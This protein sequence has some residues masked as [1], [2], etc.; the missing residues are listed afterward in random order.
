MSELLFS[1]YDGAKILAERAKKDINGLDLELTVEDDKV[2][3]I[4]GKGIGGGAG[5]IDA[6]TKAE[7]DEKYATKE[8][9][10]TKVDT[11]V[12]VSTDN[13]AALKSDG[14]LTEVAM[15]V[16]NDSITAI[17]GKSITALSQTDNNFTNELKEKLDGIEAGAEKNVHADWTAT[18]YDDPGFIIG[19]PNVPRSEDYD[20]SRRGLN[21]PYNYNCHTI[22]ESDISNKKFAVNLPLSYTNRA[23]AIRILGDI[24]SMRVV[25]SG[26][27]KDIKSGY[28]DS[29]TITLGDSSGSAI[30]DE[31]T[32]RKIDSSEFASSDRNV[33]ASSSQCRFHFSHF[34][35]ATSSAL[36]I[37][38]TATNLRIEVAMSSTTAFQEGDL[39]EI[40][41]CFVQF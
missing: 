20:D 7:S 31:P 33:S 2:T 13:L 32:I 40:L 29:V 8:E 38:T 35:S 25:R 3:A 28:M 4:G 37:E 41:V 18:D 27:G 23:S 15:T 26:G 19:K 21:L 1:D 17:G 6:Y 5:P 34:G 12:P 10:A 22:T 16:V 24:Y 30:S 36:K 39:F 9:L 11:V 14:Q